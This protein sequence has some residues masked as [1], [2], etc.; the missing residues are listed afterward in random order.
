MKFQLK[1]P[2]SVQIGNKNYDINKNR[3]KT[4]HWRQY[5]AIKKEYT[6]LLLE[7][8]PKDW[9]VEKY[10]IKCTYTYFHGSKHK[11]D[12][13]NCITLVRKFAQDALK[14]AGVIKEDNWEFIPLIIDIWGGY[15]KESYCML[16]VESI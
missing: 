9:K 8:I 3:E 15:D 10:P 14:K 2:T 6:R 11:G 1:L 5:S 13:D 7:I 16:E 4:W 12:L